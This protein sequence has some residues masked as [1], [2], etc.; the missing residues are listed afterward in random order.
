M[1][2][3]AGQLGTAWRRAIHAL[4]VGQLLPM[5]LL[6]PSQAG[7][8]LFH[9]HCKESHHVHVLHDVEFAKW[10][11]AHAGQHQRAAENEDECCAT[12]H[13]A[14]VPS[15][16]VLHRPPTLA[17]RS[18][19]IETALPGPAAVMVLPAIAGSSDP[20]CPAPPVVPRDRYTPRRC[21][22]DLLSGSHALL[23]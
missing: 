17:C 8:V 22:D 2:A 9:S 19:S 13:P 21:L 10:A 3:S 7:A 6:M 23:I 16:A 5:L 12:G 4:L 14:K 1:K 11:D 18:R 20:A 15:G